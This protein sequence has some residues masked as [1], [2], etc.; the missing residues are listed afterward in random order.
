MKKNKNVT[1][2][3]ALGHF[4]VDFTQGALSAVLPFLIAAHSFNYATAATLVMVSN[5]FGSLIQPL[6][7]HLSDRIDRPHL[8]TLGVLLS[9]GGMA[10]VGLIPNYGGLCIAVI[11]SGIGVSMFHPQGARTVN[12]TAEKD[13]IATSLG[14]FSFGGNAGFTLGP[15]AA[16]LSVTFLGLKGTLCFFVPALI[17]TVFMTVH[18]K[19][20][21]G[22]DAIKEQGTPAAEELPE[23]RWKPFVVL[24][25][26]VICRAIIFSAISTFLILQLTGEFGMAKTTGST[27]L[28]IYFIFAAL[29]S[30]IGGKLAD[31]AGYKRMLLLSSLI[32]IFGTSVFAFSDHLWLALAALLPL[33]VGVSLG[34]SSMVTLG[35]LFLPRHVGF[36]SGIT[37]GF[38]VSIGGILA[39]LLGRI[40]DV[41]GLPAIFVILVFIAAASLLIA[42]ILPK[43]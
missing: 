28:S 40:G 21:A 12:R 34:Y 1:Y 39:P 25:F 13:S 6:F 22:A 24:L 31:A 27:F 43:K 36:A 8:M 37:L 42:M 32:L 41:Y 7:G 19:N 10:C 3:M 35:Q 5:I 14:I 30:L 38:S 16:S 15:I 2:I 29:S 26:F 9:G 17:F 18:Y 23:D 11:I 33:G 20:T 4:C